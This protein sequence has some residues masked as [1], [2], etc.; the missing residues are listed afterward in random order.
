MHD[1]GKQ[2]IRQV[3]DFRLD[4][5][6]Q[7]ADQL[8]HFLALMAMFAFKHGNSQ[9]AELLGLRLDGE[10]RHPAQQARGIEEPVEKPGSMAKQ[11]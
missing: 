11:R 7:P 1:A 4:L 10:A 8:V 6:S 2:S 9:G 3:D 5:G